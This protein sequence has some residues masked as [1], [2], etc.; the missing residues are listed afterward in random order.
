MPG[1]CNHVM[2]SL[3]PSPVWIVC[4]TVTLLIG[5]SGSGSVVD[6]VVVVVVVVE[7]VVVVSSH[8]VVTSMLDDWNPL[9]AKEYKIVIL[10]LLMF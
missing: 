8:K 10:G 9:S 6:V 7:V 5:T 1:A 2:E 3:T 4:S